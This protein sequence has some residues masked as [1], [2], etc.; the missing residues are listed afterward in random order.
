MC[1]R[2]LRR[3]GAMPGQV[4]QFSGNNYK[5]FTTQAEARARYTSYLAGEM[6]D[7]RERR[8]KRMKTIFGVM[9]MLV[10]AVF[11]FFVFVA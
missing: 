11:L 6:Y 4:H 2:S 5:G 7:A 3:V 9:I 8:R 1:S 10:F